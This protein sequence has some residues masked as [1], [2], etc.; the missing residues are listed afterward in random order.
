MGNVGCLEKKSLRRG[1]VRKMIGKARE[2]EK[3][4]RK[5]TE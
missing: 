1:G 3:R 5:E 4:G 2:E